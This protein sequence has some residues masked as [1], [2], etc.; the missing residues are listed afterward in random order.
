MSVPKKNNSCFYCYLLSVFPLGSPFP[1]CKLSRQGFIHHF[2]DWL[3]DTMLAEINIHNDM[4][5]HLILIF[6]FW[7]ELK[8]LKNQNANCF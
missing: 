5:Y 7:K 2:Q 3:E 8:K 6:S 1:Q 4:N